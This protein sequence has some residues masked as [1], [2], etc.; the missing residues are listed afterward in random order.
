MFSKYILLQVVITLIFFLKFN[1]LCFSQSK[2]IL[3]YHETNGYKHS[4]IE[5]GI[6]MFED[7]GSQNGDWVT[8]NSQESN[9]FT[10]S[11]L[12]QY[13]AIVFL[14][15][16][17]DNLLTD[18]EK[19]AFESFIASGKGFIGVHA[20]TDTYRDKSW[21]FYNELVGAIIQNDPNHTSSNFNADIEV[22]KSNSITGFLGPVGSV[23]NKDDEYYYWEINGGQI[24][25]DNSVLL[26][27]EPTGSNSYDARRPI[28]WYKESITYDDNDTS[29]TLSDIKSFYTALGHE[30]TD[31]ISNSNFRALLKNATLWA[32]GST[33][34]IADENEVSEFIV[35]NPVRNKVKIFFN[36]FKEDIS[37]KVYDISGKQILQKHL[38]PVE[39]INNTYEFSVRNY[40]AGLYFYI[41]STSTTTKSF[42]VLKI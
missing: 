13:S 26:E 27:V 18:S 31:Y 29:I 39:I 33:L 4:S 7:L 9:V 17:G 23:W 15:T 32:I 5:T 21:P 20:A 1:S 35:K 2:K 34:S 19:I 28:T 38:K 8:D 6:K 40:R 11:N 10:S 41:L 12:S 22:K 42:K 24:S 36:N 25:E 16:T 30:D 37:L 3:V 14:N